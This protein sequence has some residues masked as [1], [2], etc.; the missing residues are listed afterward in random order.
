MTDIPE[1]VMKA[2]RSYL[3]SEYESYYPTYATLAMKSKGDFTLCSINAIARAILA[4]RER[5][6]WQ[7]I[8]TAPRDG[9]DIQVSIFKW[10]DPRFGRK[11]VIAN[12][13]SDQDDEWYDDDGD[14]IH[15]PTHWMPLPKPPEAS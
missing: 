5:S 2:A 6:Q 15:Q 12:C 13:D 7:P 4:E 9:S 3:A 11:T 8:E 14:K 1:D 10:N